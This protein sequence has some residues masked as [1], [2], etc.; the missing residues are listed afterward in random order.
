MHSATLSRFSGEIVDNISFKMKSTLFIVLYL[1][2]KSLDIYSFLLLLVV[3]FTA[4]F[5]HHHHHHRRYYYDYYSVRYYCSL[6]H[7]A[8]IFPGPGFIH[9]GI[10][11]LPRIAQDNEANERNQKEVGKKFK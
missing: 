3:L 10:F 7:C 1:N 11:A 4:F 8:C 2:F 9:G 6:T 5:Q